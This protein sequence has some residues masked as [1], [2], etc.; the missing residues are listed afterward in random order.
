[1]FV[2]CNSYVLSLFVVLVSIIIIHYSH[3]VYS[4]TSHECSLWSSP[5]LVTATAQIDSIVVQTGSQEAYGGQREGEGQRGNERWS[6]CKFVH[7]YQFCFRCFAWQVKDEFQQ[8]L[9]LFSTSRP[10]I[11][12][13]TRKRR[14]TW[15]VLQVV[16]SPIGLELHKQMAHLQ[17][18]TWIYHFKKS[19]KNWNPTSKQ[20]MQ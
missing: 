9:W 3:V 7:L 19:W 11:P 20:S 8:S 15:C 5:L 1:M 14:C 13:T 2:I 17:L 4:S 10:S 12:K 16:C 18:R 6:I